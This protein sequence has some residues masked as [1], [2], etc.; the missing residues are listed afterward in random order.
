MVLKKGLLIFLAVLFLLPY[1]FAQ[2]NCG[3]VGYQDVCPS[4]YVCWG[5]SGSFS[6]T[7]KQL[8][9]VQDGGGCDYS[10]LGVNTVLPGNEFCVSGHCDSGLCCQSGDCCTMNS[11]CPGW[12]TRSEECNTATYTCVA[13]SG[14]A[15]GQY[16]CFEDWECQS[17]NCNS[18]YCCAA[19]QTC[20]RDS[21]D[22]SGGYQCDYTARYCVVKT[23]A[24][25]TPLPGGSALKP[26]GSHCTYDSDC[27]SGNCNSYGSEDFGPTNGNC[28]AYGEKCCEEE[29]D[30]LIASH[31]PDMFG[32][33]KCDDRYYYL[34]RIPGTEDV[35][36]TEQEVTYSA[37]M[38]AP[39]ITSDGVTISC[40]AEDMTDWG[41][42]EI[43]TYPYCAFDDTEGGSDKVDGVWTGSHILSDTQ[44]CLKV[45][46]LT[47]PGN[48]I[49]ELAVGYTVVLPEVYFLD[50]ST[51]VSWEM[52]KDSWV[53][54]TYTGN[55]GGV[56][57]E[58][59]LPV[60]KEGSETV[61]EPV[62][63]QMALPE[64]QIVAPSVPS[65]PPMAGLVASFDQADDEAREVKTLIEE[66]YPRIVAIFD[67]NSNNIFTGPRIF[68]PAITLKMTDDASMWKES[69]NT[70]YIIRK[71]A[72]GSMA[73]YPL[74]VVQKNAI[75]HELAHYHMN[76]F[77]VE[78]KGNFR[79]VP[80]WF[81]EGIAE[82]IAHRY[83]DV[84][85]RTSPNDR[86]VSQHR[87]DIL[88]VY[89]TFSQGGNYK[90]NIEERAIEK[91]SWESE[92]DMDDDLADYDHIY[93]GAA[94]SF[95]DFF[96]N[97]FRPTAPEYSSMDLLKLN[98]MR[99]A[100]RGFFDD[101]GLYIDAPDTGPD[102]PDNAKHAWFN[103][104]DQTEGIVAGLNNKPSVAARFVG[105]LKA[106]IPF[107]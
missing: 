24:P 100:S 107:W 46:G 93:Y 42:G 92:G 23:D 35:D 40:Y 97:T 91:V 17:Y 27:V 85:L 86:T 7:C 60:R 94:F 78:S 77:A 47:A 82:Y 63:E 58:L 2:Q 81:R 39:Y 5:V 8:G 26:D 102:D 10:S 84:Y 90:E 34:V 36:E 73:N 80:L 28:C 62:V 56:D 68:E 16:G 59:C 43:G 19:G 45:S 6:G 48:P 96:L 29:H 52:N 76:G 53:V 74:D 70:L 87:Y 69:T 101:F 41:I 61:P 51:A 55:P 18:R 105:L 44:I 106:I 71:S 21:Y 20:C 103:S 13:K 25:S 104:I 14:L 72:Y 38:N 88:I 95:I 1:A 75:A 57:E 4:G 66:I 83:Y 15:D 67:E 79:K 31:Y 64:P 65:I 3:L 37:V 49:N 9:W 12:M 99:G 98:F 11:D 32:K 22:C 54:K 33:Y 89:L 30:S 50:D